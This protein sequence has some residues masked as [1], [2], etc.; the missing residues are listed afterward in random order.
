M[1]KQFSL[2]GLALALIILVSACKE[3]TVLVPVQRTLNGTSWKK[4]EVRSG[5]RD[6][7]KIL[8]FKAPDIVNISVRDDHGYVFADFQKEY[9]YLYEHPTFAVFGPGNVPVEGRLMDETTIEFHG[10]IFLKVK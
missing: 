4:F 3:K 8:T 7:F 1:K 6:V 2:A 10:E 9:I 5:D